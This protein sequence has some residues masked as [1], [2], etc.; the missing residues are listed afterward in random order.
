MTRFA[1]WL[2]AVSARPAE[3]EWIV[4]DTLETFAE[5][6]RT[7]SPSAARRWLFGEACRAL[8]HAPRHRLAQ[9]DPHRATDPRVE[10]AGGD[11][12]TSA[13]W[14]EV[15]YALRFLV[16]SKG[17]AV[18]ATLTLALGI[19]A[20]TAM[21]A[22]VNAVLFKPLPFADP[23]RL[24]LAHLLVPDLDAGEGV[25][26]ESVWSYPKYRTLL[27]LQQVFEDTAMFSNRDLTLAG[28]AAAERVRGEVVTDRYPAVLG[29]SPML[30]RAFTYDEANR[31]GATPVAM[32]G[33]GLWTRRYGADRSIVGRKVDING[34]PHIVVGVLPRGFTGLSGNA[35][36]WIPLAVSE[37]GQLTQR[38]SHSYT[39]VARRKPAVS[40]AEAT[41]AL[42][43]YGDQIYQE[44]RDPMGGG[45]PSSAT[46]TSLYASRA[47]ADVRTASLVL[48]GAVGF[49]LLIACVNLTNLLV[50]KAIARRREVAIRVAIG[51]GRGRI[52]RQFV[53]ESLLLAGFGAAGGLL[54][55]L[56]MLGTAAALLPDSEIFFRTSIAPGT[57]RIAGA[58][59]LTRVG[60]GMIGLDPATLLFTVGITILTALLVALVPAVQS[61]SIAQFET[62]FEAMKSGGNSVA[63]RGFRGAGP[64]TVLVTVQ[65]A[66][67]LIL[68]T[69]AG[70]MIRSASRLQSTSIGVNGDNVLTMRFDLPRASYTQETGTAFYTR[71]IERVRTLPGVESV[72]LA[73]CAP[74]SGGCNGTSIWFQAQ[75]RP[76]NPDPLVG[77]HWATPDYFSTMG[78][79]VIRGR[80][81]TDQDRFGQPK[82]ALVNEAAARAFWPNADPIGQT[83]RVGQGGFHEDGAQVIGIVGNVRYR[84]LET[85]ALPDVYIPAFQSYQSRMRVF[86]RTSLEPS[87]LAAAVT[88]A[89]R[90]LDPNLPPS[91][92][93]A[94]ADRVGDAMWRTR[95][96]AWLLTAFA[97][98]ALLL[99]A[100]GIFGVMAQS[101]TE[102]TGEIGIRMALGAQPRDVVSLVLG[103]AAILTGVG[104]AIGVGCALLL[105]RVMGSFL[106]DVR[107]HDP[108][109]FVTVAIVLGTVALAACYLPARRATRVDAVTALRAE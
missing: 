34:I 102:R 21:F 15:R 63:T 55:A 4:G 16:R 96:G 56:L 3:R 33:Y 71:L 78:I 29:I 13:I 85:A 27:D 44:Y 51:A 22:V 6:Q 67:A 92:V 2:I 101:V 82:V 26:R 81:F 37:P 65:I 74:V 5:R 93:K 53:I 66:L 79:G 48:L 100:I 72:G 98:V 7:G 38:H 69:G 30:G 57:P 107:P 89:A 1:L 75:R 14:Q 32:I 90:A 36:L 94:M 58:A 91:E 47:D 73:N 40:N 106:H 35:E 61:S 105:T 76:G 70:L 88:G 99:T 103:R 86:V 108:A 60:A 28:D 83:I 95:V 68:L 12:M 97:G 50:A 104:L 54:I 9:R 20:N 18:T 19:G 39:I 80:V 109:T 25:F 41:A 17:L 23:D 87:S 84:T 52:I 10:Y 42:R 11:G 24:M 43:V 77:I 64:R 49:V 8:L 62:P 46:A 45:R 31:A 59:G